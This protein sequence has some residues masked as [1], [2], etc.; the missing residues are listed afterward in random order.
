MLSTAQQMEQ[1]ADGSARLV[2][3]AVLAVNIVGQEQSLDFVG[4]VVPIE[5]FS[6]AASEKRNESRNFSGRNRSESF[7]YPKQIGPPLHAL[8][9]D[10]RRRL[11][12]KR[13]QV[14]S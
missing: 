3:T 5:K 4:L 12:E 1:Q 6:Q 13:L 11:Q 14:A 9:I 2:G 10:L 8:S 7:D